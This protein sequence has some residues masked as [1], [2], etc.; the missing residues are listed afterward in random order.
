MVCKRTTIAFA[1]AAALGA[2]ILTVLPAAEAAAR[3][4][5]RDNR[6]GVA[7]PNTGGPQGG[8]AIQSGWRVKCV[9]PFCS[10]DFKPSR[11]REQDHRTAN[12]NKKPK[13]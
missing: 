4:Q 2:A 11:A 7:T 1:A 8:Y 9:I 10:H 6:G 12:P 13:T 3:A 5:V